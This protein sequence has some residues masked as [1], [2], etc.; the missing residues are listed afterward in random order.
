MRYFNSAN[1]WLTFTA[2]LIM[3]QIDDISIINNIKIM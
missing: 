3:P 1:G 2:S